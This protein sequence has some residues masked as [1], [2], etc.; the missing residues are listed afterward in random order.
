M[1]GDVLRPHDVPADLTESPQPAISPVLAAVAMLLLALNLRLGISSIGPVLPQIL[2]DLGAT[3]VFGSLLTTVPVVMM[4][5]ASPLSGRLADRF[6]VEWTVI[7]ALLVIGVATLVRLWAVTQWLLVL[8]ALLLGIGIAA[9]NTMLPAI[10]RRYFPVHVA[11]MTGLYT[12]GI[13]VGAA[14]A[15]LVTPQLTRGDGPTWRGALATW[16]IV[17][18]VGVL[19]WLAF[20]RQFA[21]RRHR[22]LAQDARRSGYA[23]LVALFFGLQSMV[24]YG[25]LAWLAPLYEERGWSKTQAGL[26][27]S[28]MTASQIAGSLSISF[29]IQR[30]GRLVAGLRATALLNAVVLLLVSLTP[31]SA[32]WPWAALLGLG[33]G[34]IFTL[35]LTVPIMVTDSVDAAR[36]LTASTLC[37]GY[38]LASTGPFVVGLLRSAS[39]GFTWSFAALGGL[40][41]VAL[42]IARPVT[43]PQVP[44]SGRLMPEDQHTHRRA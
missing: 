5:L 10:V 37:Y 26:L 8:S 40:C 38:L 18:A 6:G 14:G 25:V 16:A 7:A 22:S 29:I 43:T 1:S 35:A 44:V 28:V 13:N 21:P 36:R 11:L 9:G 15:A 12:A 41:L 27:L 19:A 4:G 34:G 32:P 24:Y 3:V 31:L 2:H 39:G 17:A 30:T 20:V 33:T 23:W 42:V